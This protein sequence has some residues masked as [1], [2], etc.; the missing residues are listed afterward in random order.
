MKRRLGGVIVLALAAVVVWYFTR[1]DEQDAA[2]RSRRSATRM[3]GKYLAKKYPQGHVV[4][5]S[6]PFTAVSPSREIIKM[7]QAGITGLREG[8]GKNRLLKVVLPELKPTA[9]TDP[10]SLLADP[11]TPTPLS[12]LVTDDAFDKVTADA[13]LAVS[14]IGLPVELQRVETWQNPGKPRFALLLPDL[15]MIGNRAAVRAAMKN[16]K[17]AAFVFANPDRAN[18]KTPFVLATPE[19]LDSLA[20]QFPTLLPPD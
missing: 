7:E 9:R 11:E 20:Q 15:R 14:L 16:G 8:F 3:L 12:Y 19:T 6:N 5:I 1:G 10:R 17:L 18:A 4:I 2:F 13:D